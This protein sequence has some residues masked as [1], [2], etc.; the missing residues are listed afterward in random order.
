MTTTLRPAGPETREPDGTRARTYTVCVNSR[1]VGG[2]ALGTD[3]HYGPTVGRINALT[4]DGPDR[5]RGRG[6]VAALAAEEV[7]R[8]W[9][10]TRVETSV[11]A[12]AEHALRMAAAL[13]YTERNTTMTKPLPAAGAPHP[14][15]PGSTLRPLSDEEYAVWRDCERADFI[16]QL[17]GSGV[18]RDQAEVH[19]AA[20][21][22]F[23]LPD[24]RA[25]EGT[26]LLALDHDGATVGHLW[27]R[28]TEPAWVFSAAVEAD[29]R[30]RGH[31]RTLMLAAE[32]LCREAGTGAVSLNV[33]A[34]NVPALRLYDS[35][36]YRAADRHFAKPLT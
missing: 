7:L 20:G 6:T 27:L 35:L 18:P 16:A 24:G 14:L 10:C 4:I 8:Q 31:G 32:N 29:R 23:A 15:P 2:V 21:F 12:G 1:P 19:E 28:V 26:V 17:V 3:R 13:G 36:G 9:G 11:P 30:G 5:R 34:G 22:A 25:T 33:F